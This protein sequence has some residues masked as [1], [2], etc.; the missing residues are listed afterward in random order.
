MKTLIIDNYDSYTY[1]LF[2]L[3][4]EVTGYKPTVI[5]NDQI[6]FEELMKLDFDNVI[7]SP[8]PGRP[9]REEDFGICKRVIKELNKPIL[10]VCLGHQGIWYLNGGE[11]ALA[12]R[13]VHGEI[14]KI[15]HND[16]G[17]FSG[18]KQGFEVTRYHSL[19]CKPEELQDINVEAK[20][21]DGI[22]MGI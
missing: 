9:D 12:P 7:I 3:V 11:I 2:Q 20:T 14:S 18:L 10:G 13:P 17:L 4:A 19:I 5:K 15:F 8:G 16:S 21:E 1:N 22:I 6:S